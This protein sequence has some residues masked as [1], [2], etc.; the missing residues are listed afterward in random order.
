MYVWLWRVLPGGRL[1]K[2]IGCLVLFLLVVAGLLL[3][4][5][6]YLDA[7]MPFDDITVDQ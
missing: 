2:A 3:F 4:V 6:P 1:A 5:F 7:M